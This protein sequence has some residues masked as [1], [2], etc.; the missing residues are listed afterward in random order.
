MGKIITTVTVSML[1][2]AFFLS[3]LTYLPAREGGVDLT[4]EG[5]AIS[6]NLKEIPLRD[7]LEKLAGEKGIWCRGSEAVL[8]ERISVQFKEL[9]LEDGM[10][11]ILA[12]KNYSLLFDKEGR[13]IG[14]MVVGKSGSASQR[15]E[16]KT[17]ADKTTH[18]P[19]ATKSS[20]TGGNNFKVVQNYP[21]SAK[22]HAIETKIIKNAPPPS[23]PNAKPIDAKI[24]KN[25]PPPENPNAQPI[26]M[27]IIKNSPPPSNPNVHPI[28]T[29]I[30]KNHPPPGS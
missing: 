4:L 8:S 10:K 18:T 27:T 2:C 29:T 9:S 13:P 30:I 21:P 1:T 19:K 22:S 24:I 15:K 12:S 11:R 3:M 26:D 20:S 6:A 16:R 25:S 28:D 5:D 17:F 14:V 23:N 7:I